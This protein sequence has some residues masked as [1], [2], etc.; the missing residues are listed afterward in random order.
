M[1]AIANF[2]NPSTGSAKYRTRQGLNLTGKHA[3]SAKWRERQLRLEFN[4]KPLAFSPEI[5][6]RVGFEN[7]TWAFLPALAFM[8]LESLDFDN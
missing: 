5:R 1:S 8:F 4:S 7:L 2:N 6:G 3:K